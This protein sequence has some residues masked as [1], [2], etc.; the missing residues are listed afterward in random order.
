[1]WLLIWRCDLWGGRMLQVDT[2]TAGRYSPNMY[3]CG[4]PD[5]RVC[6]AY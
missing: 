4:L 2:Y 3:F 5:A 6:V 1:M